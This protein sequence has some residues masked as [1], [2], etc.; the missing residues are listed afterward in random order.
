MIQHI[1]SLTTILNLTFQLLGALIIIR[2]SQYVLRQAFPLAGWLS[3]AE[4]SLYVLVCGW[5]ILEV[6]DYSPPVIDYLDSVGFKIGKQFVSL[7]HFLNGILVILG[8]ILGALWATG[9]LENRLNRLEG[10]D[11][12][13]RMVLTRTGKALVTVLAVLTGLSLLGIDIT[14]L[15]VFTGALGVGLGFGLQKI[16]SNYVSGFILLLDRSIKI[17]NIVQ[18]D[19]K[20]QGVVTQITTRYTVLRQSNGVECLVPNEN[21]I[22]SIVK[23]QSYSDKC[24]RLSTQI[25]VAYH[26]DLT[27]AMSLM[28]S[29]AAQS[30][31]VI[32]SPPPE[33]ILLSFGESAIQLE[34]GFWIADPENG[35]LDVRSAVNLNLWNTFK[36]HGITVPFP[37]TEVR[38]LSASSS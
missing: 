32:S 27:L 15:S 26:T 3:T 23:N 37:Q 19:E 7:S 20:T 34:L 2:A 38:I 17:G 1:P 18:L 30:P 10:L 31:R 25:G 36:A 13:L 6:F 12:S 28:E 5:L 22:G 16:A 29:A 11:S 21:L 14:A 4:K 24:V 33:A 9:L 35:T 8:T